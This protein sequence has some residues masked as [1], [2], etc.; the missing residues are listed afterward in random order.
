MKRTILF[1]LAV[2]AATRLPANTLTSY[3]TDYPFSLLEQDRFE[4]DFSLNPEA[5]DFS[6]PV[7]FGVL[8]YSGPALGAG[9]HPFAAFPELRISISLT[10]DGE[11]QTF[12][13]AGLISDTS[14]LAIYV[15]NGAFHFVGINALP[16]RSS[17]VFDNGTYQL[18]TNPFDFVLSAFA[19]IVTRDDQALLA[20]L[21]GTPSTVSYA[22]G[23]PEPAAF[24][25]LLGAGALCWCAIRRKTRAEATAPTT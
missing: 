18:H 13:E 20:G 5:Y 3:F 14:G 7:G 23:I 2:T 17:T 21:Y 12:D 24:A 16:D 11:T 19:Y 10:L 1:L 8:S 15:A 9:I 22:A 6:A 25:Q 4:P